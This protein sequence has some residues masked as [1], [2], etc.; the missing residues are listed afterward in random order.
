MSVHFLE[1]DG[2]LAFAVMPMEEYE[3][4]LEA[5]EDAQDAATIES[6][7]RR[8]VA[9]EEETFPAEIVDRLLAD[10]NPVRVFREYR[11][12]TLRQVGEACGVSGAHVSQVEQGRRSMSVDLLKRMAAALR[13]DVELLL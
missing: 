5:L 2:R 7:Y 11:G 13:V 4:L 1:H 12:M 8:L 6:F 10:E 9:G 3:R